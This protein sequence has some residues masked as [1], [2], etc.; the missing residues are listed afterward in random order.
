MR[1]LQILKSIYKIEITNYDIFKNI[2]LSFI[3]NI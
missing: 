2:L 3:S 1:F